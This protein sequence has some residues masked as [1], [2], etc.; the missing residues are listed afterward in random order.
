MRMVEKGTLANL[1]VIIGED[2]YRI[3]TEISAMKRR[4]GTDIAGK[5]EVEQFRAGDAPLERIVD[6]I[7]SASFFAKGKITIIR[8]IGDYPET[9]RESIAKGVS[10]H[11][12]ESYVIVTAAERN[13]AKSFVGFRVVDLSARPAAPDVAASLRDWSKET[14]IRLDDELIDFLVQQYKDEPAL[15]KPELDKIADFV[16]EKKSVTLEDLRRLTFDASEV[17]IFDFTNALRDRNSIVALGRLH[18]LRNYVRH[19]AQVVSA[20]TWQ[21]IRSLREDISSRRNPSGVLAGLDR[22]YQVDR[23]IKTGTKFAYELL[24]LFVFEH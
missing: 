21:F 13:Q 8:D 7:H 20:A 24:E 6:S 9:Q 12:P 3:D 5:F 19:P 1:T 2:S 18:Q 22:L 4:L 23:R 15:L 16:A 11:P 14:H 10:G 17:S